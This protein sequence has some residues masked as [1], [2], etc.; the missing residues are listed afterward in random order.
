VNYFEYRKQHEQ[1]VFLQRMQELEHRREE[2]YEASQKR[3]QEIEKK[4]YNERKAW[5]LHVQKIEGMKKEVFKRSNKALPETKELASALSQFEDKTQ[6][7]AMGSP[8]FFKFNH[9]S[10]K[11][12]VIISLLLFNI[13]N[14]CFNFVSISL[15]IEMIKFMTVELT[16]M[17]RPK[18]N[19]KFQYMMVLQQPV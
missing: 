8:L 12:K 14:L 4:K 6:S 10:L 15:L 17:E 11:H 5:L 16:E 2:E 3:F 1:E 13:A 7:V 9:S 19:R 18:K